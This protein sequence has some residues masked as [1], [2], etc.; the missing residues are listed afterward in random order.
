[1]VITGVP[2]EWS[3]PECLVNGHYRSVKRM[4]ITGVPCEWSL[5]ECQ[6]NGHYRSAL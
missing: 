4:V 1:M 3:L 6:A 2:S 5:P